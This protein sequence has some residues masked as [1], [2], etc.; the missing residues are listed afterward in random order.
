MPAA[1]TPPAELHLPDLPEVAVQLG[2]GAPGLAVRPGMSIGWR[3]RETLGAYLPL[4]MMALVAAGTWWLVTNTPQP[5]GPAGDVPLRQTPDYTMAGF[6]VT[7]FGA[8]GAIELR[9]DGD[10]LRHYPATDRMEVDGVQL[11]AV[12]RDGRVSDATAQRAVA[13]S[14]GS[15]VEL[16]GGAH[17]VSRRPGE[18]ALEVRSE[19][20][21]ALVRL[22]RLVSDRPVR[23]TRGSSTMQAGGL[24]YDHANG[25]LRLNGP[26]RMVLPPGGPAGLGP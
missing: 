25:I 18:P 21:K 5:P 3:I 20:L 14:D 13:L 15:E 6:S 19:Q 9:L 12:G 8:D 16:I 10:E 4:L 7:R 23:V 22:E 11:H 2:G 24:D 17:V 1:P 26:V